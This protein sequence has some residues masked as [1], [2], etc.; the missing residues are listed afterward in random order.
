MMVRVIAVAACGAAGALCRWGLSAAVG[1]VGGA[2]FPAGTLSANLLGC[3]LLGLLTGL[4]LGSPRV[5]DAV[6]LPLGTG[7]LGSF[8][9]FSTFAVDTVQLYQHGHPVLAALNVVI[10]IVGGLLGAGLGLSLG[11]RLI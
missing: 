8:T 4:A 3:L 1:K 2:E 10:S 9:T 6:K 7:F 11:S 5:P